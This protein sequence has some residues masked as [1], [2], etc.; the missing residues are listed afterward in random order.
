MG[1]HH[2]HTISN[3]LTEQ[4]HSRLDELKEFVQLSCSVLTARVRT[5]TFNAILTVTCDV[6]IPVAPFLTM[7]LRLRLR[8]RLWLR[9]LLER[10][11]FYVLWQGMG[12]LECGWNRRRERELLNWLLRCLGCSDMVVLLGM[13]LQR[14]R[15]RI[16]ETRAG[17]MLLVARSWE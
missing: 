15:G 12:C 6:N 10:R 8:L 4:Q 3:C 13:F 1:R 14:G 11:L 16:Y 9:L 7:R 2:C 17:N 5:E